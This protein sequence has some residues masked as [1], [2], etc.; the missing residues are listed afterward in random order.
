M[1]RPAWVIC[2]PAC[3]TFAQ[4]MYNLLMIISDLHALEAPH[5]QITY[6]YAQQFLLTAK[7]AN[8]TITYEIH[9]G[10]TNYNNTHMHTKIYNIYTN[11]HHL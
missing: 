11:M 1:C 10:C 5:C 3:I 2:K 9:I 6:S 4:L 7:M 8:A